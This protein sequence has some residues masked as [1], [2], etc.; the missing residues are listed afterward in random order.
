MLFVFFLRL[1]L[2]VCFDVGYVGDVVGGFDEG[3]W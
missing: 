3:D 2:W 1:V